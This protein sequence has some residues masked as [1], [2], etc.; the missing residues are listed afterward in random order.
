[1]GNFDS[2]S[3]S[4]GLVSTVAALVRHGHQ[5]GWWPATLTGGHRDVRPTACPG[6][7]L[8]V[9]IAEINRQAVV[10]EE[11]D[12]VTLNKGAKGAAVK[13]FQEGLEGWNA[14]ALPI[15]GADGDFGAETETWVRNFQSAQDLGETGAIDGITG[16]LILEYR[17]DGDDSV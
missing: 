13:K 17:D 3:V 14:D 16:A 15:F 11:D 7:N 2:S 10:D 4:S 5:Q 9:E 8:Y 12:E 6:A 1:M